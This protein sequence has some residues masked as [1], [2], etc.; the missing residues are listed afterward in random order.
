MTRTEIRSKAAT[1]QVL[2]AIRD[3]RRRFDSVTVD[4]LLGAYSQDAFLDRM[5]RSAAVDARTIRYPRPRVTCPSRY[6]SPAIT[7]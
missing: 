4:F 1:M 2:A 7:A 5:E 3:D 6:A